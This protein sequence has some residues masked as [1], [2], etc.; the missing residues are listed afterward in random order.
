MTTTPLDPDHLGSDIDNLISR[1]LSL[2]LAQIRLGILLRDLFAIVR[3][4]HLRLPP[5]LAVL[6]KTLAMS[7]G[8][9][10]QLDPSFE[11]ITAIASYLPYLDEQTAPPSM[12]PDMCRSPVN[13]GL[14][15]RR[16]AA[17]GRGDRSWWRAGWPMASR[18]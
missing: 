15:V 2:P 6:A 4:H 13:R 14:L 18:G 16:A 12:S 3:R 7:E 8:I 17:R 9:A 11:M 1:H 10:A 5:N